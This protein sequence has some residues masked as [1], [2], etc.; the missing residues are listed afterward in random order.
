[1]MRSPVS[2]LQS[3]ILPEIVWPLEATLK[4]VENP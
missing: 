4:S 3:R 2:L 1:M